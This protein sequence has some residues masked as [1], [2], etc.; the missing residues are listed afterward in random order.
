M[1]YIDY[2][3]YT[4]TFGGTEI[5]ESEFPRLAQAASDV[6]DD[7]VYPTLIE[8]VTENVM[9]ATA[10]E[11]EILYAQGGAAAFTGFSAS[12]V[13]YESLGD[14]SLTAG[15]SS[16]ETGSSNNTLTLHGIPISELAI[17]LLRRD[18]LLNR[19]AGQRRGWISP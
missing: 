5:P 16:S 8:T 15:A 3:Y 9:R 13:G 17:G 11:L 6:I 7:V 1:A 12:Q 14:Y 18:G 19:W 4:E 2:S 10:Y